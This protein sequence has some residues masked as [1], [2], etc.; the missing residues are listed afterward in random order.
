MVFP[1]QI[2]GDEWYQVTMAVLFL[3]PIVDH[4]NQ[5][6]MEDGSKREYHENNSRGDPY[7]AVGHIERW[8]LH[9]NIHSGTSEAT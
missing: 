4:K 9:L 5:T 8:S 7:S 1:N 6:V 2:S 3:R